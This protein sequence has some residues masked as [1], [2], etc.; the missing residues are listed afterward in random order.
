MRLTTPLI[1]AGVI[2]LLRQCKVVVRHAFNHW[3]F[4]RPALWR[5]ECF[6]WQNYMQD[7]QAGDEQQH[8]N[9]PRWAHTSP[10]FVLVS[11]DVTQQTFVLSHLVALFCAVS[12]SEP[13]INSRR[14]DDHWKNLKHLSYDTFVLKMLISSHHVFIIIVHQDSGTLMCSALWQDNLSNLKHVFYHTLH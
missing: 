3:F 9:L 11:F 10:S 6:R 1:E 12:L 14:C 13:C 8:G 5:S 2:V 7:C 4:F